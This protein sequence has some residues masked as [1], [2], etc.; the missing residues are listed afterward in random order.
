M[1][2]VKSSKSVKLARPRPVQGRTPRRGAEARKSGTA[3]AGLS[4]WDALDAISRALPIEKWNK[5][6]GDLSQNHDHYLYGSPKR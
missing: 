5:L 6:P 3:S 2:A 1:K 4:L